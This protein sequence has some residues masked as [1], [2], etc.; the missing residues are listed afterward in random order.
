MSKPLP[1]DT[2]A[3]DRAAIIEL[4]HRN[5][6]GIWTNDFEL[7]DSCFVHADYMTRW[8]WW[9]GG[10]TYLLRGWAD[11]S[12]RLRADP[13]PPDLHNAYDTTI[14]DLSLQI[15]GDTAW[16]TFFQQYPAQK[17]QDH[18]GPGWRQ[19]LRIFER[20]DGEWKIALIGVPDADAGQAG[21]A[22]LR[23]DATG[24]VLWRSPAAE[25]ALAADDDLVIRADVLHFRNRTLDRQLHEGLGWAGTVGTGYLPRNGARPI[26]V[27]AGEG[28]PT[29]I[30]WLI[31][32]SG[33]IQFSFAQQKFNERRLALA[34]AIYGLSPTQIT[35]AALVAEGLS[36]PE[37]A[38]RMGVTANTAR[39]HLNR[40]FDKV[41]V[42]TQPALVRVLLMAV[43]P[44]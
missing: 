38:G 42:R 25:G 22:T 7:W 26:V 23:L 41:G 34:A 39:T 20:H 24:R 40:V 28:L 32:D 27:E 18:V 21:A 5:R 3:A 17:L 2:D 11:I 37:I 33:M 8:G 10:G 9:R 6:I 44:V 13:P 29:K 4:I 31:A 15:R 19:E 16:A 35:L 12:A 36:L 30:Y 1:S 43:A 14:E